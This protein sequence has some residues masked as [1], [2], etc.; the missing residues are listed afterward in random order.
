[1]S[2]YYFCK[3]FVPRSDG[4]PIKSVKRIGTREIAESKSNLPILGHRNGRVRRECSFND[5]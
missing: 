3:L 5:I 2:F 4:Q 1:M